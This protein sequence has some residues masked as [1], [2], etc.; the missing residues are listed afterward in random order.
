M[1]INR[2][3][4]LKESFE[5][6]RSSFLIVREKPLQF[7]ILGVVSGLI[8]VVPILGA[9]MSPLF[10]TKFASLAS[11][12]ERQEPIT[13]GMV[14]TDLFASITVVKLAWINAL[15]NVSF[16]LLQYIVD[17]YAVHINTGLPGLISGSMIVIVLLFI[18]TTLLLFA[19]WLSPLICW[20]NPDTGVLQAM[21]FS[22][23]VCCFNVATLLLYSI[24]VI[25]FTILAVIP[26]GLGL[27]IWL[28]VLSTANY[29][30]Y[31][32]VITI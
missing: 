6:L 2:Q 28:P 30:I 8:G 13:L 4:N 29:Y 26:L 16:F 1:A 24:F 15:L 11:Q 5:W 7:I 23:K 9:F 21:V 18:P 3:V 22:L 19:M 20:F 25:I 31:K 32:S 27:L 12:V 14:F 10:T 17:N